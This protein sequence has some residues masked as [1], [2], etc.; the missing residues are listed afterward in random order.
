MAQPHRFH[1]TILREYDVRGIVGETLFAADARALGRAFAT[2]LAAEGC[3][4]KI[5][6]GYD[7]RLSSPELTAA[8]VD[9]LEESGAEVLS[10]GRG[11]TPMNYFAVHHLDADGG[12]HVTGSHNPPSHNGFKLM[13]GKASFFG[14]RIQKL[15]PIAEQG[16]FRDGPRGHVREV[17]VFDAYVE[18]L[19]RDYHGT[20]PIKAVW[21]TG[22]GAAGPA[23]EALVARLPGEHEVL[24]AEVDGH[25]P[26]HHPDPTEP[27]NLEALIARVRATG[28]EIGIGF[29]GDGDRIG[30]VD[31]RGR[32]LWGDQLIQILA[33]DLLPRYPGATII[34]DVKASQT[35]FDAIAALGGKPLMWKTGHSLIKAKMAE[36]AAPMS[37]E[38]SGHI[39][40]NDN[41]YGH[42]DALYVA[43][44]LLD[45]LARGEQTLADWRDAMPDVVNTPEIRIDCADERKFDVIRTVK[46]RLA[47]EGAE[48]NDVDG[49]RVDTAD[50]WWLLRASNTQAVVVARAEAKD[51]AGLAR[52]KATI[53]R[54][55]D[56]EGVAVP[57]A[58]TPS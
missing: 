39:F 5:V 28:A 31:G 11:P 38:M 9:G 32:I 1:P 37:G 58:L 42:D 53:R 50:G 30:V 54:E 13:I 48:V 22:N 46:E 47:A 43:V 33:S 12:I 7:G 10:I 49:V 56:R 27:E 35:L 3:G 21:D 19:A 24:F 44:R 41:F 16:A 25:F 55:L 52:L 14:E 20:R 23:C 15:R 18:R 17:A 4:L 29:D 8:L 6:V 26:N 40:Y 45:V 57:A 51:A 34:A 36:L 2:Q